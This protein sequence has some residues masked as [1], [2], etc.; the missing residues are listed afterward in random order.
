MFLQKYIKTQKC[1][2]FRHF[3]R[4][5]FSALTLNE[6]FDF[7]YAEIFTMFVAILTIIVR[8]M[9]N[10]RKVF[11]LAVVAV[12]AAVN[13]VP[14]QGQVKLGLKVGTAVNHL[15]F[16]DSDAYWESVTDNSNRAGF[17]GGG[18]VEFTVPIIG[19]GFDAS[20]LYVHRTSK[21]NYAGGENISRDYIDIPINLKYKISIPVVQRVIKPFVTTGPSFAFLTGKKHVQ[22]ALENKK[23]DISWNFGFGVELLSH[24][25]VAASY[26]FSLNNTLDT[27]SD[28][29]IDGKNRYWNVTAAYLF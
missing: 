29:R 7:E 27:D 3:L 23:S 21:N 6:S 25:Q 26:G 1:L 28:Y 20:V 15:K 9:T 13:I 22:E 8:N 4:Y 18:M 11:V 10:Y 16:S 19:I 14:V 2:T 12:I 5:G 17:L 24:L